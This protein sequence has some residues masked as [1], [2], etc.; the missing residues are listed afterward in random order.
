MQLG[1]MKFNEFSNISNVSS[2]IQLLCVK[3]LCLTVIHTSDLV[4]GEL[5]ERTRVWCEKEMI[6]QCLY[7]FKH[8][9]DM[10]AAAEELMGACVK[11][12]MHEWWIGLPI[13][14]IIHRDT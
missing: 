11:S 8:T 12:C 7:E 10:L 9:E 4:S 3:S 1:R 5:G 2:V 13:H 6:G 14:A